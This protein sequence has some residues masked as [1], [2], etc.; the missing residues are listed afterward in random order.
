VRV[1]FCRREVAAEASRIGEWVPASAYRVVVLD[2]TDRDRYPAPRGRKTRV[3]R[4][5]LIG[6]VV[7][8][9]GSVVAL[10]IYEDRYGVMPFQTDRPTTLRWCGTDYRSDWSG[11]TREFPASAVAAFSL[12]LAFRY[13]SPFGPEF[14]VFEKRTAVTPSEQVA[15]HWCPGALYLKADSHHLVE[16]S[17]P[18]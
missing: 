18:A 11:A 9:L 15:K 17:V 3:T 6:V 7:L 8:S 16:Y 4:A 10:G 5:V 1:M 13:N 14:Q 2:V 12:R